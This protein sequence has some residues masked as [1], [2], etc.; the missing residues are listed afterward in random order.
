MLD[1]LVQLQKTDSAANAADSARERESRDLVAVN[2]GK[3]LD[4]KN[5]KLQ[6]KLF[7]QQAKMQK[8]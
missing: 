6:L 5:M 8:Q 1:Q 7:K 2:E 4:T 3:E